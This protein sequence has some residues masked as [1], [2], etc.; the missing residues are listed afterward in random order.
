M[1]TGTS[2]VKR[3]GPERGGSEPP[4]RTM[5]YIYVYTYLHFE[6][7]FF[8]IPYRKLAQVGI[9]PAN[10]CLPCMRS[11]HWAIWPNDEVCLNVYRIKWPQSSSHH[12]MIYLYIYLYIYIVLYV[13]FMFY[14]HVLYR[15]IYICKY[16]IIYI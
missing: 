3:W 10:L 11:N 15:I 7:R 5:K 16:C 8:A 6:L 2:W 9:E 12:C 14:L 1:G 13:I 4:L